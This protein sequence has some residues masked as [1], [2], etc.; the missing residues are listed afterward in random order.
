MMQ[1]LLKAASSCNDTSKQDNCV[2]G[3]NYVLP[4][5]SCNIN[6]ITNKL[7]LTENK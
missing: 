2:I 5:S 4:D 6:D 1:A 7:R 3:D